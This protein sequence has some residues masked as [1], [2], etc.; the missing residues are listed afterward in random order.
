MKADELLIHCPRCRRWPMPIAAVDSPFGRKRHIR[1]VCMCG[2]ELAQEIVP[3]P[4]RFE[5]EARH[6]FLNRVRE[7]P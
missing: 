5:G 2:H 1:F 4:R 3:R 6:R 7:E